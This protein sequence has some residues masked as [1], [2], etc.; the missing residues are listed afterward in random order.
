MNVNVTGYLKAIK[1]CLALLFDKALEKYHNK[2]SKIN[3]E[4]VLE[5]D[6]RLRISRKKV[7]ICNDGDDDEG[8]NPR[9]MK[10]D[11]FGDV[12]I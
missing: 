9:A 6:N 8:W 2:Q 12:G 3:L 10:G 4:D 7:G 1:I 11:N 5:Y